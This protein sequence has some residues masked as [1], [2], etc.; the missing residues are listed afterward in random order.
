MDPLFEPISINKTELKNRFCMTTMHLNMCREHEVTDQLC[1]FYAERAKGG[2]GTICIGFVTVDEISGMATNVGGHHDR[3]IPGLTKLASAIKDNGARA[4]A[5]I[6]HAGRQIYSM[7][8]PKGRKPVGPS[9]IKSNMTGEIPH[10]LTEDE[11]LEIIEN[12]GRTTE[13]CIKAGY[14][15]VEL[16]MG[17]GY[18]V[19]AFLSPLSNQRTDKWGGSEENR[20]RFGLEVL[21]SVRKA[22][23]PDYPIMARINGNDLIPGALGSG[24]HIRFAQ[25]LDQE[26]IDALCINVGWHEA[27][28]PQITMGVPRCNYAYLARRIKENVNVPV[29]ASHRIN[30]VDDARF[31]LETG[32]CDMIGM[33]RGLIADP[34]LPQKAQEGREDEIISCI[35]CGQGCFDHVFLLKSIECMVNPEAGHE[36]DGPIEKADKAK[37]VAVVGGGPAGMSAALALNK[38]GHDVT[39]FEKEGEL[40]G[41]LYLAAAPQGREEFANLIFDYETQL[42]VANVEV[43]LDHEV[44]VSELKDGGYDTV[45][46]ATGAK[47]IMPP[48]P[49][50]DGDNVIQAWDYLSG[51]V[52]AQGKVVIVG[53]GAVGVETALDLAEVGTL[54]ADTIKFLLIHDVEEPAE[55]KRLAIHGTNKVTLV[56]M[57]PKIGKDIGKSTRWTMVG[58]LSRYGVDVLK[59][60]KVLEI[61]SEGVVIQNKDGKKTLPADVVVMAVGSQSYNPLQKE[62]E[63][64]GIDVHV[65]GDAGKVALAFDAVHSG[66]KIGRSI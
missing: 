44:T 38:R 17:T 36:L 66:Y 1:A 28:I 35:A 61:N 27:R 51:N 52:D 23:G 56:E 16:L 26:G 4:V 19:S 24:P 30:D 53:G 31:L 46:L 54:P 22:A 18:I 39:L 15:M 33:G 20:M 8:L 60:S 45:V 43:V 9:A 55:L 62:L 40:G 48:I 3:F 32:Y 64:S 7:L 12:Y 21:K 25:A 58:D 2:V 29:I 13:R 42:A 11:I 14:D 37:K 6:N 65:L 10:E 49:G 59:N 34:Y 50:A 47:P 5:Q 41:Q 63:D 57:L